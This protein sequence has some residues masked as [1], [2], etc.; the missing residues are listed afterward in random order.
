MQLFEQLKSILLLVLATSTLC[1]CQSGTESA[2]IKQSR[3]DAEIIRDNHITNAI[4]TKS[5]LDSTGLSILTRVDKIEMFNENGLCTLE[6][7][8]EY[9]ELEPKHRYTVKGGPF[10]LRDLDRTP[11]ATPNGV[12]DTVYNEYDSSLQP[13]KRVTIGPTSVGVEEW[14]YD[15]M[16]NET[17]YCRRDEFS[18]RNCSYSR[19]TYENGRIISRTDSIDQISASS[20]PSHF[21]YIYD[22]KNHL[23]DDGR[24]KYMLDDQNRVLA[25]IPEEDGYGGDSLKLDERGRI[26][27]KVELYY[28]SVQHKVQSNG[29]RHRYKYDTRGL[30]IEDV[31]I[32]KERP[33]ELL[34]YN[35]Q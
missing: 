10:D 32:V 7:T 2:N 18:P 28:N 5:Y 14:T 27:E 34:Q 8:P 20:V 23:V 29:D 3:K 16:G 17:S 1:N 31:R 33:T 13:V 12:V 25:N 4:A 24:Y 30:L 35:Y 26:V 19:Y 9:I 6:L 21:R 15:N 11:T 22:V